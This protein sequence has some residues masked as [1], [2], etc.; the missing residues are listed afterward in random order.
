MVPLNYNFI[1]IMC[2]VIKNFAWSS[3]AITFHVN[4]NLHKMRRGIS[5][6]FYM[7]V[8]TTQDLA[9]EDFYIINENDYW[10]DKL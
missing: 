1:F 2:G 7:L 5:H 4:R 9:M 6:G 3:Y 8:Y 10:H